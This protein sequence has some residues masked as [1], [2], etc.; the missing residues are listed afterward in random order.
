MNELASSPQ[1]FFR[2][3][4]SHE[5]IIAICQPGIR[6]GPTVGRWQP[7]MD[8]LGMA[9]KKY[10]GWMASSKLNESSESIHLFFFGN[11]ICC[12]KPKMCHPCL[13]YVS[14]CPVFFMSFA[15]APN[16]SSYFFTIF[17]F[18]LSFFRS[19]TLL[20]GTLARCACSQWTASP[21]THTWTQQRKRRVS[22][23]KKRKKK[24]HLFHV[25]IGHAGSWRGAQRYDPKRQSP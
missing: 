17:L 13:L 16:V 6:L 15:R 24:K 2:H 18:L 5:G 11:Y 9:N 19:S 4:R 20:K 8:F 1:S 12:I 10:H 22:E 25:S 7:G 3:L 21:K 23:T 14:L